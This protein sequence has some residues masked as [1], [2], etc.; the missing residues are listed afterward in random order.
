MG[1]GKRV[2]QETSGVSGAWGTLELSVPVDM[3]TR[4]G[5]T[6]AGRV[7]AT[8]S[9]LGKPDIKPTLLERVDRGVLRPQVALWLQGRPA[10]GAELPLFPLELQEGL[11]L[12]RLWYPTLHASLVNTVPMG[13]YHQG[14]YGATQ[15]PPLSVVTIKE[16]VRRAHLY[17]RAWL[18]P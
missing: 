5:Q 3:V 12:L 1:G 7:K 4:G 6:Y 10:R 11:A 9:P 14:E 13:R 17:L 8:L 18:K 2:L 16:R 15:R